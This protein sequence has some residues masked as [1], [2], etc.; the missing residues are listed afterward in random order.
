MLVDPEFVAEIPDLLRLAT[1]KIR[2][3]DTRI[4][5]WMLIKIADR[6]EGAPTTNTVESENTV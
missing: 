1:S 5:I 2:Q 4:G 3:G 6:L